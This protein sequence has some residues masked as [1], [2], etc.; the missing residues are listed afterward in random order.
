MIDADMTGRSGIGITLLCSELYGEDWMIKMLST[1]SQNRK[2]RAFQPSALPEIVADLAGNEAV[3][4]WL[5]KHYFEHLVACGSQ[6]E[7]RGGN[8]EIK[9]AQKDFSNSAFEFLVAAQRAGSDTFVGDYVKHMMNL[10]RVYSGQPLAKLTLEL[11]K[12]DVTGPSVGE[13]KSIAISRLKKEAEMQRLQGDYSIVEPLPCDC[14]DCGELMR[15][16]QSKTKKSKVWPL[17]KQR[18]CH[19]HRM[20]DCMGLKVSHHTQRTGSPHKLIL[21]KLDLHFQ[22]EA[23]EIAKAKESLNRLVSI[24]SS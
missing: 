19:I 21:E 20:I 7:E 2:Y 12:N 22:I 23:A 5:L 24:K 8:V 9:K 15:F 18:R 13:I 11:L 1:W 14:A 16:L 6:M 3:I 10:A 17:A 4:N